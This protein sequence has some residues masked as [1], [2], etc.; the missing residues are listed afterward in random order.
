MRLDNLFKKT[1]KLNRGNLSLIAMRT[2]FQEY[3][4]EV[5]LILTSLRLRALQTKHIEQ[6]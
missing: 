1:N 6:N 2:S 4:M 5:A 3:S